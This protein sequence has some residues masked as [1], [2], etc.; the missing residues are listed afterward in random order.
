MKYNVN[1]LQGGGLVTFTPLIDSG[2]QKQ[3]VQQ[4]STQKEDNLLDDE[5]YKKL[6]DGGL[7]N[8]VNQ[9][10]EELQ[11]IDSEPQSLLNSNNRSHA[12]RVF[13]KINELKRN[14]EM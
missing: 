2:S 6:M 14:K 8:D 3:T 9:F 4:E 10:V 11:R 12:L 13:G 5:T 7:V 1:K